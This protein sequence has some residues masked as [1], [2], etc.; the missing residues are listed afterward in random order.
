[1]QTRQIM[2]DE[3]EGKKVVKY[4]VLMTALTFKK[5]ITAESLVQHCQAWHCKILQPACLRYL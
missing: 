1:M 4:L 5:G 2:K 3:L